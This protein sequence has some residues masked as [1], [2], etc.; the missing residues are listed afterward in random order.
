MKA[1]KN[2]FKFK[3]KQT[4]VNQHQIPYAEFKS[5]E[6]YKKHIEEMCKGEKK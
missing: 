6:E 2:I 3:K 4:G 1:I 5:K